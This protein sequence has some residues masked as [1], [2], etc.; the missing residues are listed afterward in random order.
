MPQAIATARDVHVHVHVLSNNQRESATRFERPAK[1]VLALATE[2]R[3]KQEVRSVL[4]HIC[5]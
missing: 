4:C 2:S 5:Q 3:A 1:P